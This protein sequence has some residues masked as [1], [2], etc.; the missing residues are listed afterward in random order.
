MLDVVLDV[1][2]EVVLEVVLDVV[3]TVVVVLRSATQTDEGAVLGGRKAAAASRIRGGDT[4]S[5]IMQ[6][7]GWLRR[8]K[9]LG[10]W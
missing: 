2:L 10:G 8:E 5:D 3:L 1:V 4:M 7:I 9:V 6:C